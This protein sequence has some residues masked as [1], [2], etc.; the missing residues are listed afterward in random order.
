MSLT[1]E[2]IAD[3]WKEFRKRI[4]EWFPERADALNKM[5]DV[6]EDRMLMMPASS[7]DHYHNSFPGGYVDHVLRVIRCAK[8]VYKLWTSM[9]AN[10]SGYTRE[11]LI[12]S[13]INLEKGICSLRFLC[14]DIPVPFGKRSETF[15]F[16]N[17]ICRF[18]SNTITKLSACSTIFL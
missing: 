5:Y 7:V 8:E 15:A 6:Y 17:S 14:R 18:A 16:L 10:M 12:F 11:E 1:A 9:G 2:Q 13:A 3:N 4:N